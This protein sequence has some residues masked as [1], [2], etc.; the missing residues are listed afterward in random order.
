[1]GIMYELL[2]N[3]YYGDA[4]GYKADMLRQMMCDGFVEKDGDIIIPVGTKL[5]LI[6]DELGEDDMSYQIGDNVYNL[7]IVDELKEEF[8]KRLQ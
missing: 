8:L 3:I 6:Q 1:M 5:Y 2:D 7:L 4:S